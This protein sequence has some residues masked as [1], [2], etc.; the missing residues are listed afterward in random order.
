MAV[1]NGQN[2][3]QPRQEM[4]YHSKP[5]EAEP[6]TPTYETRQPE[7]VLHQQSYIYDSLQC[8]SES[9]SKLSLVSEVDVTIDGL[10]S[11]VTSIED[12]DDEGG[13]RRVPSINSLASSVPTLAMPKNQFNSLQPTI[14]SSN[15]VIYS[16]G[17]GVQKNE[18]LY[19][20]V[21]GPPGQ[22]SSIDAGN[23]AMIA[24]GHRE[25]V[26]NGGARGVGGSS[27]LRK[28]SSVTN[29]PLSDHL[30]LPPKITPVSG[31]LS[32]VSAQTCFF[33]P[34]PFYN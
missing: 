11:S 13:F 16:N 6:Q 18:A 12:D 23:L 9:G 10:S 28:S 2:Y 24:N 3:P 27:G 30:S 31:V 8:Q 21:R 4:S 7:Q 14:Y 19:D 22:R 34:F 33:F 26:I 29:Y 1:T 32:A 17:N 15:S 20:A 25:P 5:A